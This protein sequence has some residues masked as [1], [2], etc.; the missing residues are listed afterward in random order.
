MASQSQEN[1]HTVFPE[2]EDGRRRWHP[3]SHPV[4]LLPFIFAGAVVTLQPPNTRR[5]YSF[6][7]FNAL[8]LD[9]MILTRTTSL[10]SLFERCFTGQTKT[11]KLHIVSHFS[12]SEPK[13]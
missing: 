9:E 1:W 2:A 11:S 4:C 6:P 12:L 13:G 7:S 8:L 10:Q 3:S 5:G